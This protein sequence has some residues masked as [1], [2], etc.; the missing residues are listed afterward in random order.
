MEDKNFKKQIDEL[1]HAPL[2]QV[3]FWMVYFLNT[4][5]TMSVSEMMT[6]MEYPRE[7][8]NTSL[9]R[10]MNKSMIDREK[11]E[12]GK[13][14]YFL[15]SDSNLYVT[16]DG[17]S[18]RTMNFLF[19]HYK[20]MITANVYRLICF[21]LAHGHYN[22]ADLIANHGWKQTAT[23]RCTKK[24]LE[25]GIIEKKNQDYIFARQVV[26]ASRKPDAHQ[27]VT[28]GTLNIHCWNN[29][30]T[31]Q[32]RFNKFYPNLGKCDIWGLQDVVPNGY[33]EMEDDFQKNGYALIF[34][35]GYDKSTDGNCMIAVL[36]INTENIYD[37]QPLILGDGMTFPLRYT[38][39]T[40]KTWNGRTLRLLNLYVPQACD[41]DETRKS[42]IKK[43]WD[44]IVNEAKACRDAKEDFILLGDL[45]AYIWGDHGSENANSLQ[46]ITDIMVD[47]FEGWN[48]EKWD[49]EN[50]NDYYALK[51]DPGFT[52]ASNS[53]VKKRLDYIMI[54]AKLAYS[55]HEFSPSIEDSVV[56]DGISDH[57]ALTLE[58]RNFLWD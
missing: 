7:T 5:G 37:Y 26:D 58:I 8:I 48:I 49:P 17:K 40:C 43:F 50:Y 23:Y 54:N 2:C 13:Y 41:A 51:E 47:V 55:D 9:T 44:L 14:Q 57:K 33:P 39:G 4:N 29:I 36:A 32:K 38:Y 31:M 20:N 3:D 12:E 52:W 24:L 16:F 30:E 21:L 56:R 11:N 28:C 10:L 25:N 45:N 46:R 19:D 6:K 18:R 15:K 34:P 27:K 35:N 53:G 22:I 1:I 42:E